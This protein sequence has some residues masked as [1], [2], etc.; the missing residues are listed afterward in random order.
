M[1]LCLLCVAKL[2][3]GRVSQEHISWVK[4]FT[5]NVQKLISIFYL[6]INLKILFFQIYSK[7]S[8]VFH[9]LMALFVLQR[10]KK[11]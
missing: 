11:S 2:T 5:L 4:I 1:I 9:D 3:V 10:S 6:P 7:H 8:Q